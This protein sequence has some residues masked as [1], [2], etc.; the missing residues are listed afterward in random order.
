MQPNSDPVSLLIWFLL[1]Q[2]KTPA[3][4]HTY[5]TLNN[6]ISDAYRFPTVRAGC[7][8]FW[9]GLTTVAK[10]LL[11][12]ASG[13]TVGVGSSTGVSSAFVCWTITGLGILT[14]GA[15]GLGGTMTGY[16]AGITGYCTCSLLTT[17]T[18]IS[19]S[20]D[21]TWAAITVSSRD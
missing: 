17:S 4:R 20:I 19:L 21:V 18:T 2:M 14:I 12:D 13:S 5:S 7:F 8:A 11:Y 16:F 6:Q 10:G 15:F 9:G 3:Q 1:H